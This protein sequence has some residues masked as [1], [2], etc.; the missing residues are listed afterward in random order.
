MYK[1]LLAVSILAIFLITSVGAI[2]AA[3]SISVK[4]V[5][6]GSDVPDHVTVNLLKDGKIVDTA[7]L[8]ASNS[9]KTTFHVDDDGNY[10]VSESSGDYSS[11]ISGSAESGFVIT[12]TLV[13]ED[14][15]AASDDDN[16][17]EASADDKLSQEDAP[18][19]ADNETASDDADS[20]DNTTDENSTEEDNST[21]ETNVTEDDNATEEDTE[22]ITESETI[23]TKIV[24]KEDVVKVVEKNKKPQNNTTKTQHK[25]TGFPLAALVCAVFVAAFVPFSRKK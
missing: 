10:K 4:V 1:K 6:D 17:E 9:W 20:T 3:D 23:T 13:K 7:K 8:S 11:Q 18:V 22:E 24:E 5:W 12:N 2:S 14:V 15:L 21:E 19:L 16:L 25:N